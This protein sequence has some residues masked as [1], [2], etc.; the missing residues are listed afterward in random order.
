VLWGVEDTWI[1]ITTGERLAAAIPGATFAQVEAAGH[2]IQ[3]DTPARLATELR[4][5]LTHVAG[6]RIPSR[7]GPADPLGW[8]AASRAAVRLTRVAD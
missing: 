7:R 3:L 1:P 8:S 5:W 6:Q 2:L 4:S